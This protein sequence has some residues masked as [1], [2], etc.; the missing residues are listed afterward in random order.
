MNADNAGAV[1]LIAIGSDRIDARLPSPDPSVTAGGL[2]I[3]VARRVRSGG[4]AAPDSWCV[5][6]RGVQAPQ[7]IEGEQAARTFMASLGGAS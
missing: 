5:R 2:L 6:V 7:F 1:R 3:A 4:P